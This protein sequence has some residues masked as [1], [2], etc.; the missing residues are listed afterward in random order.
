[1]ILILTWTLLW[2]W[3]ALRGGRLGVRDRMIVIY[4]HGRDTDWHDI[5]PY[6]ETI[7]S[8][9]ALYALVCLIFAN[10][11]LVSLG[12]RWTGC[13]WPCSEVTVFECLGRCIQLLMLDM[14]GFVSPFT[15]ACLRFI[16]N[17]ST[18]INGNQQVADQRSEML[19]I[20]GHVSLPDSIAPRYHWRSLKSRRCPISRK[21]ITTSA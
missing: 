2:I 4:C 1:M 5:V 10:I 14:L 17:N 13:H 6:L 9:L 20:S 3:K 8:I 19:F 12:G 7:T 16:Y 18:F 11:R 15:A 21:R